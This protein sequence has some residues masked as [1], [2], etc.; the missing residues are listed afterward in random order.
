MKQT[1]RSLAELAAGMRVPAGAPQREGRRAASIRPRSRPCR[2]RC[3]SIE[4]R[5]AGEGRVVLR[6]SGTEPVIRVMVEGRDEQLDPARATELAEVVR[7]GGSLR[8]RSIAARP[9]LRVAAHHRAPR[10][11]SA[12]RRPIVAGNWKMHGSRA[13][14]ARL[15]EE[16]IGGSRRLRRRSASSARRS[17]TCRKSAA[18]C[19][20]RRSYSGRRTCAPTR[21]VRSPAKSRP[22][23]SRMSAASMSSSGTRS[24]GSCIARAISSSRASSPPRRRRGWCRS[25][26]WASSSRIARPSR[27]H[28]VVGAPARCRA[29]ALRRR[30][31]WR[32]P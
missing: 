26:A 12:M 18:C 11:G 4:K 27:T 31:A 15:I 29:G 23:C 30:D 32:A 6:P 8:P 25:C 19:A 7:A 2:R 28:E 14:N 5:M 16:L 20:A 17:C 10:C 3:R 22:R 9:A 1:G 21:T 24:G 13:E